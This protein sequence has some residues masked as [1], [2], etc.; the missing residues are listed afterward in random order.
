MIH[1]PIRSCFRNK[2]SHDS[3]TRHIER[4]QHR[5]CECNQ[6]TVL[7]I[8]HIDLVACLGSFHNQLEWGIYAIVEALHICR[9]DI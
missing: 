1:F 4:H 7:R 6:P 5:S 2:Q 9:R 3:M 8:R